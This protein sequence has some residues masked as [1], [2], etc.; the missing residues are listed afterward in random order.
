MDPESLCDRLVQLGLRTFAERYRAQGQTPD[1]LDLSFEDRL[2]LLV[3]AEWTARDTARLQRRLREAHLRLPATPEGW[4]WQPARGLTRSQWAAL[5]QGRPWWPAY[6]AVLITGPTGVGKT[7]ALCALGH[8]ACRQGYRVR[9]VRLARWLGDAVLA[10][11][12]GRWLRWLRQW[13]RVDLV[14]VD[15]WGLAP[16]TPAESRDWLEFLDDRLAQGALAM[17]SQVPVEQWHALLPEPTVADAIVDRLAHQAW[18]V[19]LHGESMRKRPAAST[20]A[21]PG[22]P[23]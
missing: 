16:L 13:S 10:H 14:C 23:S 7:Y 12:E 5:T 1:L 21:D 6:P 11:Q 2:G 4:A 20:T 8:A 3:D 18:R 9:Y 17:A 15:D 19:T 22:G